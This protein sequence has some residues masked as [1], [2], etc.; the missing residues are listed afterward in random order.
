VQGAVAALLWDISDADYETHDRIARTPNEV[1]EGIRAC[2]VRQ[3]GSVIPYDGMDHFIWC[4][5]NRSPYQVRVQAANTGRDTVLTFFNSRTRDK[6]ATAPTGT[7]I[8]RNSDDFRR[9]W[10]HTLYARRPEVGLSPTLSANFYVVEPD[11]DPGSDC[12][13]C[14]VQQ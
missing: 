2:E 9:L 13:G 5:E 4:M 14:E 1:A 11:P 8:L 12:P 10:L 6:W 3:G 7:Q